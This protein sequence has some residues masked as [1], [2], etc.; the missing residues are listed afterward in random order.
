MN[1][2]AYW[3]ILKP[4]IPRIL[5]QLDRDPDSPHMVPLTG[6]SGTI[7]FVTFPRPLFS[8]DFLSWM[9]ST[10]MIQKKIPSIRMNG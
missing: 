8:R 10:N 9:Y 5:G 1:Q 3:E 6:I 2:E 4:L 7:K